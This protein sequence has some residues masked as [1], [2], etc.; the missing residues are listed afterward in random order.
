MF[1]GV[2]DELKISNICKK[3]QSEK[4][5]KP[6][7]DIDI[8]TTWRAKWIWYPENGRVDSVIRYFRKVFE[9]KDLENMKDAFLQITVDDAYSLY[10]N[11]VK[12]GAA[13][14]WKDNEI[15]NVKDLL[16]KGHNVITIEAHEFSGDEG[17]L[18]EITLN[19]KNGNSSFICSDD[20]WK[21]NKD[22]APDWTKPE[23]NDTAWKNASVICSPPELPWPSVKYTFLGYK[24]EVQL[25]KLELSKEKLVP[26][27]KIE[28]LTA[29]SIPRKLKYDYE[30]TLWIGDKTPNDWSDFTIVKSKTM[31]ETSK[32]EP[33]GIYEV[34][35]KI[36]IPAWAP[37]GKTDLYLEINNKECAVELTNTE[38]LKSVAGKMDISRAGKKPVYT[39]SIPKAEIKNLNGVPTLFIDDNAEGNLWWA[40]L[41]NDYEV[42]KKYSDT[43]VKVWALN[44]K[45]VFL[46]PT[47]DD[48]EK[49]L[50]NLYACFE[51]EIR[52]LL[53][54]CPDAYIICQ[55]TVD[56]PVEWL[57][58]HPNEQIV[59]GNGKA[60]G[61]ISY[62][63]DVWRKETEQY[64]GKF[65]DLIHNGD[66][67]SRVIGYHL[68]AGLSSEWYDWGHHQN[69]G[70][71]REEVTSGDYSQPM[72]ENFRKW[73]VKKY[74]GDVNALKKA[75]ND[76]GVDFI[77]ATI[78]NKKMV[79]SSM[80]CFKD[81][82]TERMAIDYYEFFAERVA[83]TILYFGKVIKEKTENKSIYGIWGGYWVAQTGLAGGPQNSG[84]LAFNKLLDSPYIDYVCTLQSYAERNAGT[85]CALLMSPASFVLNGKLL[86]CEN[87]TRTFLQETGPY[88][89]YTK[90][91]TISIMRR[92]TARN[93]TQAIGQWW[94]DLG[95]SD[96][97]AWFLD[98]DLLQ[99]IGRAKQIYDLS[100]NYDIRPNSEI[101]V[102]LNA[103]TLYYQGMF[104]AYLYHNLI[105]RILYESNGLDTLGAPYDVLDI[106]D[107]QKDTVKDYKVYLFLNTFYLSEKEKETIGKK[108]KKNNKT[109]I[110]VYAPGF[111]DDQ[112]GLSREA[113]SELTG[114]NINL[115][116]EEIEGLSVK[117]ISVKLT[118]A[119][120][121]FT[122][123]AQKDIVLANYRWVALNE[124]IGPVFFAEPEKDLK[125]LGTLN[126][127]EKPGLCYKKFKDWTS[128]YMAIPFFPV[129]ILRN[130]CREAGV[131]I[132]NDDGIL[133]YFNNNFLGIH[134]KDGVT[135]EIKLPSETDV[136]D[137]YANKIIATNT[138]KF[139]AEVPAVST[140]LYFLGNVSDIQKKK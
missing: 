46:L 105:G 101:A 94:H 48:K 139:T 129:D 5:T 57:S 55:F 113:M 63:S 110:W 41:A 124:N 65:I 34:K 56:V 29:F 81:P 71:H 96:A 18:C 108:L 95:G 118:D 102:I 31:L 90:R 62:G 44:V 76:P 109:L 36:S 92:D 58:K 123:N 33:G 68:C 61:K 132:Y 12:V 15:Y 27:D 43:G 75:W 60:Y 70:K 14:N 16:K 66:Y 22:R 84:Y 45:L 37:D 131:H 120:H 64:L 8:K 104:L 91:E 3:F 112:R 17:V 40:R 21:S 2:I 111:V 35:S 97:G 135:T 114:I 26:G 13:G 127:N 25:E 50:K 106:E 93:L 88:R 115:A 87:D 89:T 79:R 53:S 1:E 47:T 6:K 72:L 137:L 24:E 19:D 54:V 38:V 99:E 125:V 103:K 7:K 122:K 134:V 10:L 119:A 107:I 20:S 74:N 133:M 82:L 59:L 98:D 42:F 73:L 51:H 136:Y 83:D 4:E 121:P 28:I 85:T 126:Y 49:E 39:K 128:V 77:N 9:I 117:R 100:L 67:C 78:E 140:K 52:A 116:K 138:G 11:E 130:I 23:F 86:I 69:A 32:W 80:F 30:M